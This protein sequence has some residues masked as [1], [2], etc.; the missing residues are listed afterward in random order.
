MS[1][2][3]LRSGNQILGSNQDHNFITENKSRRFTKNSKLLI[4]ESKNT[5]SSSCDPKQRSN[6]FSEEFSKST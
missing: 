5:G 1:T 6:I 3:R 2:W 4:E